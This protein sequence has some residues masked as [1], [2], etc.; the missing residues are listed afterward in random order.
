[1]NFIFLEITEVDYKFTQAVEG[2]V[3]ISIVRKIRVSAIY[4]LSHT[5]SD[6]NHFF[7]Q[8]SEADTLR[9]DLS[10]QYEY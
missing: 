1:M 2:I 8:C 9:S 7:S 10:L 6:F 5:A 4:M 3:V